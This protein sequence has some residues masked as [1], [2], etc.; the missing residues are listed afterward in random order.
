MPARGRRQI[1]AVAR[2]PLGYVGAS[3]MRFAKWVFLSAGLSGVLIVG[4]PFFLER[5]AGQDFPPAINHDG[6]ESRIPLS[7]SSS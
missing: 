7:V 1:E 4:P 2:L 3:H 5:Y 6:F